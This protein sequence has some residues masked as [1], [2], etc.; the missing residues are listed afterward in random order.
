M[1]QSEGY[2]VWKLGQWHGSSRKS[3][4]KSDT[5]YLNLGKWDLLGEVNTF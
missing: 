3:S 2:L 5:A 1:S 4:V